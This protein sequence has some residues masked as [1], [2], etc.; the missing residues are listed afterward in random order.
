MK[1]IEYRL[2]ATTPLTGDLSFRLLGVPFPPNHR[3]T[4]SEVFDRKGKPLV[5][6]LKQHFILEGR[7]TDDVALKIINDGA[8]LLRREKT[9][10]D[11][12]APLTGWLCGLL[13]NLLFRLSCCLFAVCGDIHGQFFDLMKLFEVG[14]PPASTRYL[15][16]GDYVDRGY[17]SIEAG[18][19]ANS[20]NSSSFFV[21]IKADYHTEAG[22]GLSPPNDQ[23]G[24]PENWL[25]A[26]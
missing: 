17:F 24:A 11:V 16:L 8:A 12:E 2:L 22:S 25:P 6:K 14:G 20:F 7:V 15:F 3:L 13:F 23:S 19:G 5:D 9:M 18:S 4:S 21:L 26:A 10:I 1:C